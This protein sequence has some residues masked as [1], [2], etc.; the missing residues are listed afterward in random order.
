MAASARPPDLRLS[1]PPLARTRHGAEAGGVN[2]R[3]RTPHASTGAARRERR[4]A[5]VKVEDRS[6]RLRAGHTRV[7]T[8]AEEQE[9]VDALADLLAD[10]LV[11]HPDQMPD[12]LRSRPKPD[13]LEGTQTEEQP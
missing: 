3:V 1:R 8:E 7:M 10:W 2:G 12:A 11:A 5:C 9:L 6:L 13:L 4:P